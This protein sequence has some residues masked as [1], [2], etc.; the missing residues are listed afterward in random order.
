MTKAELLS[1]VSEQDKASVEIILNNIQIMLDTKVPTGGSFVERC[2]TGDWEGAKSKADAENLVYLDLYKEY[3]QQLKMN[4]LA[5][6]PIN[7]LKDVLYQLDFSEILNSIEVCLN[8][9]GYYIN[10]A[11]ENDTKF[12]ISCYTPPEIS[13]VD[14]FKAIVV[15]L[16]DV[17]K[18]EYVRSHN[19]FINDLVIYQLD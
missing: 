2:V 8:D 13:N 4:N 18:I 17:H 1:K 5:F 15:L 3:T 7:W 10:K 11:W 19:P 12:K 16:E 9:L 6:M 14:V